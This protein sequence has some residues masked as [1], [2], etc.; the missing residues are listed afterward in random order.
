MMTVTTVIG[1]DQW[2]RIAG[3]PDGCGR[4]TGVHVL[5]PLVLGLVALPI[6]LVIVSVAMFTAGPRLHW[7]DMTNSRPTA[8]QCA[9]L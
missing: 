2:C 9:L 4:P 7:Q 6:A 1:G 8:T 3:E 5:H